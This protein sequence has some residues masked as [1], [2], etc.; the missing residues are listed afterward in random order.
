[1]AKELLIPTERIERSILLIRVQKVMLDRDLADLYGVETR[2]LVQAVKRN[3]ERF[4]DDFMFQLDW[5]EVEQLSR[6]QIVILKRGQ[7]IKFRPYSFTEQGVAMLS[8]VL[9]SPRAIEVNIAI[10]RAFVRLREI[11]A[12][13]KNFAA[14]L[15][16]LE[17]KLGEHD[18]KFQVV[19]E[20]I[21]QL[22]VPPPATKK[23]R[24]GFASDLDDAAKSQ[25]TDQA[26]RKRTTKTRS[27]EHRSN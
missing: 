24:I 7:N 27:L 25:A 19:F 13:H 23:R 8:S 17:K 9:R 4:P 6:S 11:L 22:M 3:I 1:M 12:T 14:K 20:A 5:D 15:A 2:T 21:H 26:K 18:H 16:E 10:M